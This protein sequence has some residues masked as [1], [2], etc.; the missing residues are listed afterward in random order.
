MQ[1]IFSELANIPRH[2]L[3]LTDLRIFSA[4]GSLINN[5][6]FSNQYILFQL[7]TFIHGAAKLKKAPNERKINDGNTNRDELIMYIHYTISKERTTKVK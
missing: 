3:I 5:A 6:L 2:E 1:S 7:H 4:N